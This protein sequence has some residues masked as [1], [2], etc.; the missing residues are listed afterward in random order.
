MTSMILRLLPAEIRLCVQLGQRI[1]ASLDTKAE[2]EAA[3]V[4]FTDALKDGKIT[5]I[6]WTSLG[7]SLGIFKGNGRGTH[8]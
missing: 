4:K 2:R 3:A 1:L 7:K 8:A 5:T 6:E